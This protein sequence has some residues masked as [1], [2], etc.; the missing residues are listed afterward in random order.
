MFLLLLSA[1]YSWMYILP[2]V[3]VF[4]NCLADVISLQK[5]FSRCLKKCSFF[6]DMLLMYINDHL[7]LTLHYLCRFVN[8]PS[9]SRFK[10][11][12]FLSH[13]NF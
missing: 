3:F 2:Y 5:E 4:L 10:N 12:K 9:H 1:V 7:K 11:S 13:C 6:K 8:L